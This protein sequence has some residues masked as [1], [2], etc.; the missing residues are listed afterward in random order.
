[1]SSQMLT[2]GRKISL[3]AAIPIVALIAFASLF[4]WNKI[5]EVDTARTMRSNAQLVKSASSLISDLQT[6]RGQSNLYINGAVGQEEIGKLRAQTDGSSKA[7]SIALANAQIPKEAK[8][9]AGDAMSQLEKLRAKVNQKPPMGESF[10]A[11]TKLISDVVASQNAAIRGKTSKGIGKRLANSA[12]F[13]EAKENAGRLRGYMSGL[14][15]ANRPLSPEEFQTLIDFHSRIYAAM[16]SPALSVSQ[17]LTKEIETRIASSQ[18]QEVARVF[19]TVLKNADRGE[20]GIDPVAF[21]RNATKQVEDIHALA[22]KEIESVDKATQRIEAE[23]TASIWQ[24]LIFL[25]LFIAAIVTF[26]FFIGRSIIRPVSAVARELSQTAGQVAATSS[27]VGSASQLLA[28]GASQQASAL[29]QTAASLEEMASMTKLSAQHAVSTN[30]LMTEAKQVISRAHESMGMLTQSMQGIATASEETSKIIRTIDEIAFQTNLL[31]LNAAV[32]AARAGEAGAG[33]AVVADEVRNLAMRAAD[34]AKNTAE[35]IEGTVTKVKE[36]SALV[37]RTSM[38]FSQVARAALKIDNL[39]AEISSAS[40]EQ[41]IG[42]EQV[43]RAVAEMD[44]VTQ[45]NAA[46]AEQSAAASEEMNTQAEQ[47]EDFVSGLVA[48]VGGNGASG[49]NGANGARGDNGR[50]EAPRAVPAN[51][52]KTAA[53]SV[54]RPTLAVARE[55]RPSEI[56][57][58]DCEDF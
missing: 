13:E 36:G 5:E 22:Q 23:E 30:Q 16:E 14:L 6:E 45:Q 34:A 39:V 10:K 9:A 37:D 52:P 19:H 55:A 50:R 56:I 2:I 48:L 54:P 33:F 42:I 25:S 40:Q 20:F 26:S 3:L 49:G 51:R 18:W 21:F 28:E 27:Q 8:A 35:M 12:L 38:E 58:F 17:E 11:Y 44:K 41:A 29:E 4:I 1:M 7:Y 53:R 32:E 24:S 43:N 15:A 57:P 46:T 47:M 31:A